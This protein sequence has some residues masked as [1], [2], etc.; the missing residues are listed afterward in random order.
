[1]SNESV[2]YGD[3]LA[4]SYAESPHLDPINEISLE[5]AIERLQIDGDDREAAEVMYRHCKRLLPRVYMCY[6]VPN[7]LRDDLLQ[8][9][10][11]MLWTGLS[12]FN[13]T[14]GEAENFFVHNV[15]PNAVRI[16]KTK[17]G[18]IKRSHRE[19]FKINYA[20]LPVPQFILDDRILE[21]V[22]NDNSY[23]S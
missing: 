22:I 8:E 17:H 14:R 12:K 3:S 23:K 19:M 7:H 4:M 11:R 16:V 20:E 6:W 1:M 13:P 18:I 15:G 10:M 2:F 9:A 5:N 21:E